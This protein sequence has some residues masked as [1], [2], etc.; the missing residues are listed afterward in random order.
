MK[1]NHSNEQPYPSYQ[2]NQRRRNQRL[3][4][5]IWCSISL[6]KLKAR[7]YCAKRIITADSSKVLRE[8]STTTHVSVDATCRIIVAVFVHQ[9]WSQKQPAL[10]TCLQTWLVLLQNIQSQATIQLSKWCFRL[11]LRV[12][13]SSTTSIKIVLLLSVII[14]PPL[15]ACASGMLLLKNARTISAQVWND[16]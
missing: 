7:I 1:R 13:N 14:S 15:F 9:E 12:S 16:K 10:L 5:S 2:R 3:M 11:S 6:S 4:K 8:R